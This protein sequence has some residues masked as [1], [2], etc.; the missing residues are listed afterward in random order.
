[1]DPSRFVVHP[2]SWRDRSAQLK[3]AL[4]YQEARIFEVTAGETVVVPSGWWMTWYNTA[5]TIAL[6]DALV[7]SESLGGTLGEL[8]LGFERC[9]RML[10]SKVRG[11]GDGWMAAVHR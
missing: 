7:T 8:R 3:E 9:R 2:K 11:M 4:R 5:P 1:M 10:E 6:H